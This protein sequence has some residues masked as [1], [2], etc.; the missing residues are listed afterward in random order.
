MSFSAG[1]YQEIQQGTGKDE[2]LQAAKQFILPDW[3]GHRNAKRVLV[4]SLLP[5][6]DRGENWSDLEGEKANWRENL[7]TSFLFPTT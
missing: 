1:R 6:E 5:D 3:P 7:Q 2:R 4:T